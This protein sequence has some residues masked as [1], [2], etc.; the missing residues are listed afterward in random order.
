MSNFRGALQDQGLAHMR[1]RYGVVGGWLVC[2]SLAKR[3][4]IHTSPTARL[5]RKNSILAR[6]NMLRFMGGI[7]GGNTQKKNPAGI[8][9]RGFSVTPTG[10]QLRKHLQS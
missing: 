3:N 10:P 7:D 1:R 9:Q 5:A 4:D 6:E 2:A 8:F